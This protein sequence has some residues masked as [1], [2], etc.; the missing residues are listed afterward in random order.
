L[1]FL[2]GRAGFDA[3]AAAAAALAE[4]GTTLA[5]TT[6]CCCWLDRGRPLHAS[7]PP[8]DWGEVN[9]FD[10]G[11]NLKINCLKAST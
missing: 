1:A 6:S 8:L 7:S 10:V 5:L 9:P 3:A 2:S 4:L 11:A